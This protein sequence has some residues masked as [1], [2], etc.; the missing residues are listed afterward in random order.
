[1]RSVAVGL[2]LVAF[3]GFALAQKPAYVSTEGKY[4]AK[5]PDTPKVTEKTAKSAAGDLTVV[6]ASYA[7]SDGSTYVVS[8]TDYPTGVEEKDR[9]SFFD[10]VRD[11]VKGK[12]G[13]VKDEKAITFG[14]EKWPGREF[15][16]TK[17]RQR[18]RS[19]VILR[20]N[21]MYHASVIGAASFVDGKEAKAFLESLEFTK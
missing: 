21:R 4:S 14:E 8:Y 19:R 9:K 13:E 11:G 12:E 15:T 7:L 2:A 17:D 6:V 18:I 16:V 1:M 3:A 20:D 10:G 5:F